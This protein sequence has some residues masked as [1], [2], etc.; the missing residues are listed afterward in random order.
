MF[1]VEY[2][3]YIEYWVEFLYQNDRF[4]FWRA[5]KSLWILRCFKKKLCFPI[6]RNWFFI[7]LI[8]NFWNQLCESV[9]PRSYHCSI[10]KLPRYLLD[11]IYNYS[12]TTSCYHE[13]TRNHFVQIK[14]LQKLF[15]SRKS[16]S[17]KF[18]VGLTS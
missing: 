3:T 7:H 9:T 11:R 16:F 15:K 5:D 10:H 13:L 14:C 1:V 12:W 2:D 8:S 6:R 4:S 17:M 18:V